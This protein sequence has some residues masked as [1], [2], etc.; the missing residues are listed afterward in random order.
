MGPARPPLLVIA[1]PTA[2]GKTRLAV[3]AALRLGAEI[4]GADSMQIYR[5]MDIGTATPTAAELRGV[6]HHLLSCLEPD[7]AC[8]AA[9]YAAEAD[10]AIADI[11]ARG[12][13]A[14]VAGG[15]GL[16]LRALLRGL[17]AAPPPDPE[18][19]AGILAR[20]ATAGWPALHAELA[21]ADPE[22]A[23][24]LH[25]N[26]GARI[27]RALEVLRQSG[28]GITVWQRRHGFAKPRYRALLLGVRVAPEELREAIRARVAAMFDAGFVEE[29]RTLLGRG[30]AP[31]LRPLQGLGYRRICQHLAG[32]LSLEEARERTASDTWRFSRRQRTWFGGEPGLEWIAPDAGEIIRRAD[33][34]FREQEG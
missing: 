5:G 10:R 19:R 9:R 12:P 33:A 26:D 17:H 18:I 32:E 14:I 22:T 4:V 30:F 16:W 29:V 24:R 6:P 28:E 1:G 20:A 11:A 25:R 15:T 34:F 3:E 13:R 27:L 31:S 8:D 23:G 21:A 7:E 2:A